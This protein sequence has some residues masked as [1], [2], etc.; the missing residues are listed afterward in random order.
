MS[1]PIKDRQDAIYNRIDEAY[2]TAKEELTALYT[3]AVPYEG[4]TN[5][6]L[7]NHFD[8]CFQKIETL[9]TIACTSTN[10]NHKIGEN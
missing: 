7:R 8:K 3:K 6:D 1:D 5:N 9:R 10:A 2:E 4:Y